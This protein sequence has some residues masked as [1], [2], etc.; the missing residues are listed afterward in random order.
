MPNPF[1]GPV[2]SDEIVEA[3]RVQGCGRLSLYGRCIRYGLGRRRSNRRDGSVVG[4]RRGIDSPPGVPAQGH[5]TIQPATPLSIT[6]VSCGSPVGHPIVSTGLSPHA[7][8]P[9][10]DGGATGWAGLTNEVAPEPGFTGGATMIAIQPV[11]PCV[12]MIRHVSCDRSSR[13]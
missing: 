9:A 12:R 11:S 2:L 13:W 4:T 10:S 1:M 8:E 3:V 7:S 5:V 6:H